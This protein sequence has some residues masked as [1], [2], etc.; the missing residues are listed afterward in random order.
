MLSKVTKWIAIVLVVCFLGML[1]CLPLMVQD[2]LSW[3]RQLTDEQFAPEHLSIRKGTKTVRFNTYGKSLSVRQSAT[4]EA[5]LEIR[6][7]GTTNPCSVYL[8]Y[9]GETAE[10]TLASEMTGFSYSQIERNL[11][12]RLQGLPA[13]I[14]YIPEDM[15]LEPG[16][17][18]NWDNFGVQFSNMDELNEQQK[19]QQLQEERQQLEEER[20]QLEE[21]RLIL[22]NI[23]EGIISGEFQ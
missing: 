21:N 23:S 20:R 18:A 5:Y 14:L 7:K 2:G 9:D 8:S 1:I 22:E 12:F 17:Y 16:Q 4:G 13:V 3:F 15:R 10:L 6:D 11:A 19:K